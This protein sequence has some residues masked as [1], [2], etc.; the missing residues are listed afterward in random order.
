[1]FIDQFTEEQIEMIRRELA[2]LEPAKNE[3]TKKR[4]YEGWLTDQMRDALDVEHNTEFNEYPLYCIVNGIEGISDIVTKNVE[5]DPEYLR[6]GKSRKYRR[7]RY[8]DPCLVDT[9]YSVSKEIIEVIR[10]HCG[11]TTKTP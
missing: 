1:M 3:Q 4:V 6:G 7:K 5:I 9:Y 10:K 2:T 8:I 11:T